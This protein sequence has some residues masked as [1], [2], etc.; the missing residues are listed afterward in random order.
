MFLQENPA[1][2]SSMNGISDPR[3]DATR[4][5]GGAGEPDRPLPLTPAERAI[6]DA[7]A[8]E[9]SGAHHRVYVARVRT[10]LEG[11]R[12]ELALE[13]LV[14]RHAELR[15]TYHSAA[16]DPVRRVRARSEFQLEFVDAQRWGRAELEEIVRLT[17]RQPMDLSAS[18]F[19]AV[20]FTRS[21]NEHVVLIVAHRISVGAHRLRIMLRDLRA[22][23]LGDPLP[24][25]PA[26]VAERGGG[27]ATAAGLSAAP[28][29]AVPQS[30]HPQLLQEAA[31]RT[32]RATALVAGGVQLS[33]AELDA[34]ANRMARRLREAGIDPRSCVAFDARPS[35]LAVAAHLAVLRL[36]A[37][38]FPL[39]A[40]PDGVIPMIPP[41]PGAAPAALIT[42]AAPGSSGRGVAPRVLDLDALA[43]GLESVSPE[44]LGVAI[45]ARDTAVV[46]LAA[47][48]A[49]T[50]GVPLN[51]GA[52]S[53]LLRTL[54]DRLGLGPGDRVLCRRM[55]DAA[56][57]LLDLLLPLAAGATVVLEDTPSVATGW[58]AASLHD[59]AITHFRADA[60]EWTSLLAQGWTGHRQLQALCDARELSS[61]LA[62]S[63]GPHVGRL[64]V[65][66]GDAETTCCCATAVAVSG[67]APMIG[68]P[69]PG[70]AIHLL[71]ERLRPVVRE[72]VGSV[73][74]GG[75]TVARGYLT[76]E[77]NAP[78]LFFPDPFTLDGRGLLFRTGDR[79][80]LRADGALEL[81][82]RER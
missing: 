78:E 59:H 82:L 45:G 38:T 22:L 79:A 4:P 64:H 47:R 69:L 19:R 35:V 75:T 15:T 13:R 18:V 24:P 16:V 50:R 62:A 7:H 1:A 53:T 52:V 2:N 65:L 41:L 32:P 60:N 74:I 40:T 73:Y 77:T 34:L 80:R 23:Y 56:A 26:R 9:L 36:G 61:E 63:L 81:V 42:R 10:R 44:P 5:I 30:S 21:E 8:A 29:G 70:A 6:W 39:P 49:R 72:A 71:D 11:E 54:P 48:E 27:G 76:D 66:F 67:A 20:L 43:A 37:V 68:A 57:L 58:L 28:A 46:A 51:H 25:L 3:D 14:A 55:D 17:A 12:L 33:F 31:A